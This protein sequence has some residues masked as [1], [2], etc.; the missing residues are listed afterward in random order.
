MSSNKSFSALL[1]IGLLIGG[2]VFAGEL[3]QQTIMPPDLGLAMRDVS[4]Q[5]RVNTSNIETLAAQMDD[6][7]EGMQLMA[8]G[9]EELRAEL[10]QVKAENRALRE[11]Q[12][13][14]R[15]SGEDPRIAAQRSGA[16]PQGEPIE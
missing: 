5:E 14:G 7:L 15:G 12:P 11:A 9:M 2:A 1:L 16:S 8:R 10:E 4:E 13:G 3:R 6:L